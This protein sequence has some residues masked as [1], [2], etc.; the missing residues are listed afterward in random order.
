MTHT[1]MPWIKS[2]T[3]KLDDIRLARVNPLSQLAYFKLELLA[4]KCDSDGAFIMNGEQLTH[5]EI[6]FYIRMDAKELKKAFKEL[7]IN[8]LVYVNGHGPTIKD[9]TSEQVSQ[10]VR[11]EAWKERQER[12]RVT[13]DTETVTRDSA[14]THAPRTRVQSKS[15]NKNRKEKNRKDQTTP[16]PPRKR[17]QAGQAGKATA[18][19]TAITSLKGK[20]RER[21][22]KAMEILKLSG[23]RNP[24]LLTLSVYVATRNSKLTDDQFTALILG[25]LA[26]AYSDATAE[27]KASVAA[28]R[29]EHDQVPV[30]FKNRSEWKYIPAEILEKANVS[31]SSKDKWEIKR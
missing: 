9:F 28:Y 5:D 22:Y 14:V 23:L 4:G 31:L 13:R 21:A 16:T 11:R 3:R 6:A 24:K 10:A 19:L 18:S 30:Q 17:D 15:K 8:K 7:I 25:A 20:Q 2:Y 1:S 12:H 26:S 29:L 27:N